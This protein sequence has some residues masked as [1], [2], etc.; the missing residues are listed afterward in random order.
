MRRAGR[1][2]AIDILLQPVLK[3]LVSW[4]DVWDKCTH[5][6]INV[7]INPIEPLKIVCVRD[8]AFAREHVHA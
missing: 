4:K 2:P 3:R 5:S 8:C 7:L 1:L 6:S